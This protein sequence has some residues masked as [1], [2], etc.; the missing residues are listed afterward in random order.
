ML[1]RQAILWPAIRRRHEHLLSVA[2]SLTASGLKAGLCV[3]TRSAQTIAPGDAVD[4][5][6]AALLGLVRTIASERLGGCAVRLDL[7]SAAPYDVRAVAHALQ[8]ASAAEPEFGVRA[9]QL[10]VPRLEKTDVVAIPV[11]ADDAGDAPFRLR[12]DG[13]YLVTV[14]SVASDWRRRHG[15]RPAA[16]DILFSSADGLPRQRMV[17]RSSGCASRALG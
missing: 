5:S 14:G 6:Q 13:T 1:V 11:P 12:A 2:Q 3:V 17:R 8:S 15:S 4:P 10:F 7:D 9:G 16:P